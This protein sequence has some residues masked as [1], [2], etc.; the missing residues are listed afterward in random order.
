MVKM[1]P[2]EAF[3]C[4]CGAGDVVLRESYKPKTRGK[5]YYACPRSK[6]RENTFGCKFFLWK[7]E[8]VR[9][10]VGSPGASTT[11]IYSPGSSSTPIYSPGS[12]TPPRYSLGA[13]TPQSYSPG[14]SR[15]AQCSNCKH[16]LDKIT[17]LE[18]TVDMYMHPE[19][20]TVNS[21]ALFHEVYNNMG[22]L[23]LEYVNLSCPTLKHAQPVGVCNGRR[24]NGLPSEQDVVNLY[25]R[26]GITRMRIY[27]PNQATLQALGG[28][29]I[30]LILDVPNA[31]LQE[32]A[33]PNGA[34]SWVRNNILN[35]PDVKFRYISVGNEVDPDTDSG[36]FLSFVL[37]AM[38]NVQKAINDAGRQIKVS[39]ATYTG[40]LKISSPPSDGAFKDNVVG[41][42]TPIIQF[43]A[44]NNSPMLANIYP[45]FAYIGPPKLDDISFALFTKPDNGEQYKNLF[46]AMYDAHLA[47]QSRLGGANV[48]IVVSESGWPSAGDDG[49]ATMENAGTYY[50][51][52]IAHVKRRSIETYL[53]A[54]F[55]EDLKDGNESEKHFGVFGRDQSNK[56]EVTLKRIGIWLCGVCFKTHT[57]RSKCRHGKG[58][59]VS[60]PDSSDGVVQFVLYDVTKPP[61]PS[62]SKQHD[63]V[64][65]LLH[66]QHGGFTLALL[67]SLFSKGLRTVNPSLP[68]VCKRKICN[69]HYTAAVRVL[70]FSGVAPYS[71]AT[72]EDLKTKHP[73]KHA[74]ILPAIP[75]DHHYLIASSAVV[76]DR[77]KSFPRG[78]SCGRDGLRAQHLM[79]C[80]SGAV[81]AIF[82][83]LV[84]S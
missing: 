31:S 13:S 37:P 25:Q 60:P 36:Q 28:T 58:D 74:P 38:Q 10:L 78:T 34:A 84:S 29:N 50:R 48:P 81:V 46:D 12:S 54:M 41:Y 42:I 73:L 20:H 52:L 23:D 27:D 75:I 4:P 62:S 45:Y 51:N 30:E 6:P 70:S 47:A 64:E 83:E 22:K 11:P 3:A 5:L 63:H 43:L 77:I 9:L 17:V 55:D 65:D 15:N 76:L 1:V 79:D 24:G 16:L 14:T 66:D 21:A 18:A 59:F 71:D 32:L 19:Q 82:D 33:D 39:T 40:L 44:E 26:N 53:F 8:R 35:Y 56:A 2:Y 57:L 69:G 72:L 49:A 80:L 68:N 61:V 7:E 67:D